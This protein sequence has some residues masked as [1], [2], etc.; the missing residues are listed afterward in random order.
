MGAFVI[1]G[2][3]QMKG[4]LVPQG[5]KNEAL[6]VISAALLTDQEVRISNVPDILDVKNLIRLMMDLG[7]KVTKESEDTY[8]FQADDVN[9]DFA[10]SESPT[11][12]LRKGCDHEA[13][14]RQDRSAQ[15]R[16]SLPRLP[17]SGSHF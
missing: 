4:T 10:Y 9:L 16:H 15:T 7:V 2:G 6:Q 14:R 12:T 1:E 11:L 8:C 3:R 17:K 13:G 5:A